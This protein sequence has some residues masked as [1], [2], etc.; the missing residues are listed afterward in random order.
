MAD[1]NNGEFRDEFTTSASSA[2]PGGP[3]PEYSYHNFQKPPKKRGNGKIIAIISILLVLGIG[4]IAGLGIAVSQ[5]SSKPGTVTTGEA[6]EHVIISPAVREEGLSTSEIAAKAMPSVVGI[7]IYSAQQV[8]KI[9]EASGIVLNTDGYIITN[10]H[11]VADAAAATV[12]LSDG[13]EHNAAVIGFDTRTDLAVVKVDPAGLNL[14]PAEFGDSTKCSLGDDVVAM[15]NAGGYYNSV[16]RGVISGLDR[17]VSTSI[18]INLIQTDA[19]INPGNSGG[20]LVNADGQ[21]V[22]INTAIY[23]RTGGSLGIG[24]AIPVSSAKNI[25]EQII[26]YG[27][28]TRGWIGVEMQ[29]ITPELAESFGLGKGN[30][31]ASGTLIAGVQRGSP[32]DQGQIKPG[33][34]LLSVG[35]EPIK[36]PQSML[37]LIAAH[38]PGEMVAFKLQRKGKLT[39]V[40][41]RIG[42]RPAPTHE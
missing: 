19:A 4:T 20:A 22:G 5:L 2:Q 23:S 37:S 42:K 9:G 24:F 27:A 28:V 18:G 3:V 25:M 11:V 39:E 13:S 41:L 14:V 33:D 35:N 6:G 8:Q 16:T 12:V 32:A 40:S 26:Q 21:L 7:N 34:I 38:K 30:G 31:N 1:F 17:E 29:E 36:D 10:A 15:G